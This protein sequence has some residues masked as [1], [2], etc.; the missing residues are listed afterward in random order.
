[1]P[2]KIEAKECWRYVGGYKWGQ[3]NNKRELVIVH[4]KIPAK[5]VRFWAKLADV[6]NIE[7]S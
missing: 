6:N 2:A 1:M 7:F 4:E 3:E 5:P